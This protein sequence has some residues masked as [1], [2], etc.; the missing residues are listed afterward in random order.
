MGLP[1]N[2]RK[3]FKK[4]LGVIADKRRNDYKDLIKKYGGEA[5][6]I[7]ALKLQLNEV[8]AYN[9]Q[10]KVRNIAKN[11]RK[12]RYIGNIEVIFR[13]KEERTKTVKKGEVKYYPEYDKIEN[14]RFDEVVSKKELPIAIQNKIES[15]YNGLFEENKYIVEVS[16]KTKTLH[17]QPA[18]YGIKL[19]DIKM[20]D[21]GAFM[22]DGYGNHDWDTKTGRCVFDYVIYTYK[23]INGFKKICTYEKLNEIFGAFDDFSPLVEG[24]NTLQIMEFC[25]RFDLPMYALDDDEKAFKLFHPQNRNKKAPAMMFR[26][27]NNHFYPIPESKKKAVLKL[28]S[29]INSSSDLITTNFQNED[30]SDTLEVKILEDTEAMVELGKVMNE[31]KTI[32]SGIQMVNKKVQSFN[33]KGIKYAINQQIE[34]TKEL[35]SNMGMEYTGQSVSTIINKII[36]DTIKILPKSSHNPNVFKNLLI[37]KKNRSFGGVLQEDDIPLLKSPNTV[38]RDITKCYASIMYKPIEEWI[39]LDFND[40]WE[41][42]DERTIEFGL[43]LVETEDT[44]LFK[45]KD[46]YSAS[47]IKKAIQEGINFKITHQLIPKYKESKELFKPVLD[48]IVEY[49][50]GKS[51]LYKLTINMISGSLGKSKTSVSKCHIN[52]DIEHIFNNINEYEKLDQKVF[53]NR[54]PETDY[55]IYGIDNEMVISETNLPMYIQ[56]LDQAN[57]KLYDMVKSMNGD[58]IARKSDCAIVHYPDGNLPEIVLGNEWGSCRSCP[59]PIV[60][61][62]EEFKEKEFEFNEG[63]K[64]WNVND[65]D[66]WEKIMNIM[67]ENGGMLL[68][69]DAGNGKSYVAKMISKTISNVQKLAPTN[70]AALNIGGTTIHK[71]LKMNEEGNISKKSLERIKRKFKYIIVDEISMITKEMWRRL[72]LLKQATGINFLLIGDDKQLPPVE[73]DSID[74]YFNHPAVKYLSNNNR[75]ILTIK[76]RFD[77]RLASYLNNVDEIDTSTFMKNETKR[78]ICFLNA[79]RKIVNEYWNTKL[80]P[81]DSLFIPKDEKDEYTQDMYIHKD[82][83]VIA[84][85]TVQGGD[86]CINN[87]TFE[88][89]MINDKKI[90]LKN[91]RPSEDGLL[92]IHCIDVKIEDFRDMFSLN[93][94]STTHKTQGETIT[95]N[96]TIYDWD[97]MSTKCRYTALSRARNPDQISFSNVSSINESTGFDMNISNKIQGH[98][99]YD[100]E[101]GYETNLSVKKVKTLFENQNGE[102]LVCGCMMK[103][104]GYKQNDKD[105]FSIDRIDSRRGHT[106]DNIQLLC[107]G[108]NRAKQNR[109]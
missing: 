56:V 14:I 68:Q 61:Y 78:N 70:K 62:I 24:V 77:E 107:W 101:K 74:D 11:Y 109:F 43:F 100:D 36:E 58:L 39:R 42:Y 16:I 106:D 26:V 66:N 1:K 51:E 32:P 44:T 29:L 87:E 105:Q 52:K 103:T 63:W 25:R 23:D 9:K 34:L 17:I 45:K 37:A 2:V 48:K 22:V 90:S 54:I 27:S 50:Q 92:E 91:E 89:I 98:K 18:G 55:Y 80:K 49:S 15:R 73:D 84:R 88:V 57:I 6:L 95:E 94:C 81:D 35:T 8:P 60:N 85:K 20:R 7:E 96:F 13:V 10:L 46:I 75:N 47:I 21:A 38:A 31:T 93:Y 5:Q 41:V 19:E 53:I 64:D 72:V 33:C 108:C 102:C 67:V 71:F 30:K 12:Q 59:V 82:L 69:A 76:K 83:P 40:M 104:C 99:K 3:D 4:Y 65:S 79:T 97:R 28:T 86:I